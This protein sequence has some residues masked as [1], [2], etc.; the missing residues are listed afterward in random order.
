MTPPSSYAIDQQLI[1]SGEMWVLSTNRCPQSL[2]LRR[3]LCVR[4]KQI[5]ACNVVS[6]FCAPQ[7]GVTDLTA[8]GG[9]RLLSLP[10]HFNVWYWLAFR[11][12]CEQSRVFL[13]SLLLYVFSFY[14]PFI[15]LCL[16]IYLGPF[17]YFMSF[18][19]I[20]SCFRF[21]FFFFLFPFSRRHKQT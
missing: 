15:L 20:I 16:C 10:P 7:A 1:H 6:L 18:F 19:Y 14:L 12:Q 17:I 21:F 9:Q 3:G 4:N 2:T 13:L 5:C 8:A 11:L